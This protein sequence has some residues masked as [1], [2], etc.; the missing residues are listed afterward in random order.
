MENGPSSAKR[1][2]DRSCVA[3]TWARPRA[4]S[5]YSHPYYTVMRRFTLPT[6]GSSRQRPQDNSKTSALPYPL[7]SRRSGCRS[8]ARASAGDPRGRFVDH[9]PCPSLLWPPAGRR[10]ER[11]SLGARRGP[12]SH[13]L[14]L[15]GDGPIPLRG[16]VPHRG[17]LHGQRL[18]VV[19]GNTGIEPDAKRICPWYKNPP[20]IGGWAS[21]CFQWFG[22]LHP[23]GTK[24]IVYGPGG[25][26]NASSACAYR[27]D[28]VE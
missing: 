28:P 21:L 1:P 11:L 3:W 4:P 6:S 17:Q 18:L 15:D 5:P 25:G 9:R 7:G 13:V 8:R 12:R 24:T 27:C 26:R 19:G 14:N 16:I 2:P 20:G 10:D 22:H 23:A